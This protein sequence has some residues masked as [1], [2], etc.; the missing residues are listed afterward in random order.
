MRRLRPRSLQ[1]GFTLVEVLIASLLMAII[2]GALGAMTAQWMPNW[3]RGFARVQRID[4][5]T[6]GVERLIADLAAAEPISTGESQG[7]LRFEGSELSV[8]FVRTAL[9]P[10]AGRTLEVVHIAEIGSDRGPTLVRSAA[11]FLPF[12]AEVPT[13]EPQFSNPV[14]VVRSPHR[15]SFAYAGADG[16][17]QSTWRNAKFLPQAIRINVRE[18]ASSRAVI[19][20]IAAV[21]AVVPATCI[22]VKSANECPALGRTAT[23]TAAA[24][25][26]GNSGQLRPAQPGQSI[27][28]QVR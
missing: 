27:P 10:N 20:T 22:H 5:L 17:W 26:T 9:G 16:E 3:N 23:G 8:T 18:G 7:A 12:N 13:P 1:S 21:H 28:G 24:A 2:V 6:A 11:P 14:V 25:Q 19:S 4:L 15:I